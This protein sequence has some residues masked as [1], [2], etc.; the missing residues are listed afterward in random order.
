MEKSEPK[1]G[2]ITRR[3]F[4]KGTTGALIGLSALSSFKARAQNSVKLGVVWPLGV[5]PAGLEMQ[6]ATNYAANVVNTE[7]PFSYPELI[8]EWAGIP[9]LNNAKLELVY[10]DHG[11]DPERAAQAVKE[12]KG[13]N[14]VGILGALNSQATLKASE[15]A[16]DVGLPM[17][18]SSAMLSPLTKRGV[19]SFFRICSDSVQG[20]KSLFAALSNFMDEL[21]EEEKALVPTNYVY[22][23]YEYPGVED[24]LEM[25]R[26]FAEDGVE[27]EF[28]G[29][30]SF[31]SLIVENDTPLGAVV[32]E[33]ESLSLGPDDALV[34]LLPSNA[35][36]FLVKE[37]AKQYPNVEERPGI[38]FAD[39]LQTTLQGL[40]SDLSPEVMKGWKWTLS[41]VQFFPGV[42]GADADF[43]SDYIGKFRD[44]FEENVNPVNP[45]N[46]LGFT[47][48]HTW[49]AILDKAGSTRSADIVQAAK[50]IQLIDIM[51]TNWNGITFGETEFG[52]VN[53]NIDV[54]PGTAHLDAQGNLEIVELPG[55]FTPSSTYANLNII[56]NYSCLMNCVTIGVDANITQL[57][58]IRQT[59][60]D[61]H[62]RY[63]WDSHNTSYSSTNTEVETNVDTTVK[64]SA[65]LF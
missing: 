5:N 27:G 37:L 52:D 61:N 60:I 6:K 11:F 1:K 43:A 39:P 19:D 16:V 49:A 57:Q 20:A 15:A 46:A 53:A 26:G 34:S 32:D 65:S 18:T 4:I 28:E 30:F 58:S 59:T 23:T 29:I 35:A 50:E 2:G 33:I 51:T 13:E 7:K 63:S 36:L 54:I 17:I 31:D 12:L 38:V 44:D 41:N 45:M 40:V 10:K 48:I 25:I 56:T 24:D 42:F 22:L 47:G 64:S 8:P 55:G 9:G 14:V 21:S 62:A 3:S